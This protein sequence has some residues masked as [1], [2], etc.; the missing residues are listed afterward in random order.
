M[1]HQGS[2]DASPLQISTALC[3]LAACA[4][5]FLVTFGLAFRLPNYN[6]LHMVMSDL[7][8]QGS[9]VA[10]WVSAWWVAFGLLMLAFA[11]G[12]WRTFHAQRSRALICALL[13]AVFGVGAGLGA[14]T[15]PMDSAGSLPTL[16]GRLHDTLAGIGF[17]AL[18]FVPLVAGGL[19]P[20]R[21]R[22]RLSIAAFVLGMALLLLFVASEDASQGT[23]LLAAAGL[24]QR[25]FLLDQYTY[26]AILA[27]TMVQPSPAPALTTNP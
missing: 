18:A 26:L 4:G 25:L 19:F 3:G 2:G 5:D 14:G 7:G 12:V 22:L 9:P 10:H 15:F 1:T 24:W 8:T 16:P 20:R 27:A 17:V 13:I 11:F 23:G 6:H 21:G